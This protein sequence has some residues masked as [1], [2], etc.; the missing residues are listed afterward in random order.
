MIG[1]ALKRGEAVR[2]DAAG[3]W[4]A[5]VCVIDVAREECE[6]S[7][8]GAMGGVFSVADAGGSDEVACVDRPGGTAGGSTCVDVGDT[9]SSDETNCADAEVS[10]RIAGADLRGCA[11]VADPKE[12]ACGA[13]ISTRRPLN[14]KLCI[15]KPLKVIKI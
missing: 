10:D 5:T 3:E 8:V 6:V 14:S 4:G 2:A 1:A 9:I 11:C 7:T 15:A 13:K 12:G